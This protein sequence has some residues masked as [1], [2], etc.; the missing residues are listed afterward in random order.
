MCIQEG[1]GLTLP[2][3]KAL[4]SP[5]LG[6]S[7]R[8]RKRSEVPHTPKANYFEVSPPLK[9]KSETNLKKNEEKKNEKSKTKP[10]TNIDPYIYITKNEKNVEQLRKI[11]RNKSDKK[12]QKK[13]K[14]SL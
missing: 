6:G 12:T 1:T 9:T 5:S 10:Q 7:L 4:G 14:D 8:R 11:E 3:L 2:C 13:R